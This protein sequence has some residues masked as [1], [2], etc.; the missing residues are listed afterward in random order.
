MP[1]KKRGK[2]Q[3]LLDYARKSRARGQAKRAAKAKATSRA[4][5]L[6]SGASPKAAPK[7][8]T[9]P[10]AKTTPKKPAQGYGPEYYRRKQTPK[11]KTTPALT[12]VPSPKSK[13]GVPP[14]TTRTAAQRT[15]D[16]KRFQAEQKTLRKKSAG[17][18]YGSEYKGPP[19][20]G[21]KEQESMKRSMETGSGGGLGKIAAAAGG[22]A[23]L[24]LYQMYKAKRAADLKKADTAR[25][26]KR[27]RDAK[28]TKETEEGYKKFEAERKARSRASARR[29]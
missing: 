9:T 11:P 26:A 20:I 2:R 14:R 23:S 25:R 22:A 17:M 18:K 10:K 12:A 19:K 15:A 16:K 29:R 7:K 24:K 28:K 21:K 5:R 8:K 27:T 6:I 1:Y 13:A 3:Q 4:N